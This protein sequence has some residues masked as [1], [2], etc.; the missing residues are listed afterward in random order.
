[1]A[2]STYHSRT[3]NL[4]RVRHYRGRPSVNDLR[5][6]K[7]HYRKAA[8]FLG[9]AV[10]HGPDDRP[11]PVYG[12]DQRS[13]WRSHRDLICRPK[14]ILFSEWLRPIYNDVSQIVVGAPAKLA[15]HSQ[16]VA[17][18][19][20]GSTTTL[21]GDLLVD[22]RAHF[23]F[24]SAHNYG[25]GYVGFITG[26]VSHDTLTGFNPDNIRWLANLGS[27]LVEDSAIQ[28][29]RES[30]HLRSADLCFLSHRSSDKD[31]VDEVAT[32]LKRS[33]IAVW[34]DK[35]ELVPSDSLGG[36]ISFGLDRMTHYI[37]FWSQACI[38]AP[39]IRREWEAATAARIDRRV[40]IIIVR[41][42]KTPIPSIMA[43][44]YRIEAS[45]K[46]WG[47]I[48]A[49]LVD[50]VSALPGVAPSSGIQITRAR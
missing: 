23:P 10:D 31:I 42:D 4:A 16:L 44:L 30:S 3:H 18:G 28:R 2:Y 1:M 22:E 40:P 27:L 47:E 38:D 8:K 14:N 48:T 11:G 37:L 49:T 5:K 32:Q 26:N 12:M 45:G 46:S 20:T 36:E 6:N 39:W 24:A 34:L 19:N 21:Q 50:T 9:A 43:D 7:D 33:G 13:Y 41:L 15:A 25:Y 17:T 29:N 35:N